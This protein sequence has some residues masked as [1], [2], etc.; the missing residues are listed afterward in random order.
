MIISD[1]YKTHVD[2]K[3]AVKFESEAM[4]MFFSGY[5]QDEDVENT[6]TADF[7]LTCTSLCPYNHYERANAI[8]E[9]CLGTKSPKF[10]HSLKCI[11]DS[12]LRAFRYHDNVEL[13]TIDTRNLGEIPDVSLSAVDR[14]GLNYEEIG[15]FYKFVENEVIKHYSD[16]AEGRKYAK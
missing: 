9:K 8:Y 6:F 13:Y 1:I 16:S 14:E 7:L 15:A 11:A 5:S 10:L 3:K 12:K 4:K 2:F